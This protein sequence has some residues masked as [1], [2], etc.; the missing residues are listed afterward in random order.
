[1]TKLEFIEVNEQSRTYVFPAG[2]ITIK[3]VKSINVS[4]SGTHRIN[5][6]DG[7]K[8]IVPTGWLYIEFDAPEWTF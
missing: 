2:A 8:Y 5:T 7:K 1:M 6:V 3:Q 4:K